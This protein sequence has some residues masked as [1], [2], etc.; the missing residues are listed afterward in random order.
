MTTHPRDVQTL[1]EQ[2]IRAEVGKCSCDYPYSSHRI[3]MPKGLVL[4]YLC[5][6]GNYELVGS[7]ERVIMTASGGRGF[8]YLDG[9]IAVLKKYRDG[10]IL[11]V[12]SDV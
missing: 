10:L 9:I 3:R 2:I 6:S 7:D 4:L 5:R 8:V 11:Q 12:L 1:C